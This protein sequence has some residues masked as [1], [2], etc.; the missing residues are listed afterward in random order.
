M[1]G[2]SKR[3]VIVVVTLMLIF[4][5]VLGAFSFG[6]LFNPLNKVKKKHIDIMKLS[7]VDVDGYVN[8]ALLGVDSRKMNKK[9]I[10]NSRTDAIIIVS[11]NTKTKEVSLISVYRDTYTQ[12]GET[13]T[14]QKINAAFNYGGPEMTLKTLNRTMDLNIQNY[15]LFN[16]RMVADLVDAVGGIEVNVTRAEINELNK[17]TKATARN[18]GK[19]SYHLAKAPGRQTLEGVQA[20]SYGRIRKGVGDDFKR[21]NRMRIVIGKV[22]KKLKQMNFS[23]ILKI[24][25]KCLPQ[26]ETSLS[27]DDM[28]GLA[29]RLRKME[30]E[31]STGWP[32]NVTTGSLNGVS[33]VFP[34]DL[35][36]NVIRLHESMFGQK[37]YQV[38]DANASIAANVDAAAASAR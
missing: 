17:Y 36:A 4:S 26:I 24:M 1:W 29:Q 25:N 5:L 27:N 19:K 31:K 13:S 15:V 8:I 30:I 34:V 32:Y 7:C 9:G 35:K 14:Y 38:S 10:K 21:T 16:F 11:I 18:I 6:L 3:R 20:V 23:Q 37:G 22:T 28:I 12:L 33:Y 2:M